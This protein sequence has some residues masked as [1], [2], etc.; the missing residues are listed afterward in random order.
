MYIII[1]SA[2]K[3]VHTTYFEIADMMFMVN[4]LKTSLIVSIFQTMLRFKPQT[5][6]LQ[7]K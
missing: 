6:T 2:L 1:L 5:P 7:I 4:S 3:H